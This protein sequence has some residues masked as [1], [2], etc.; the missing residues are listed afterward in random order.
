[1]RITPLLGTFVFLVACEGAVGLKSRNGQTPPPTIL[2]YSADAGTD[3][4]P[5]PP[6]PPP[7]CTPSCQGR[8]CGDDGCGGVCGSCD[9]T[10]TC[11]GGSCVPNAPPPSTQGVPK[12]FGRVATCGSCRAAHAYFD[13]HHITYEAHDFSEGYDGYMAAVMAA[14]ET[15][16]SSISMPA[17]VWGPH[18]VTYGWSNSM[19]T[20]RG[21]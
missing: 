8:S 16:R 11:T 10:S 6:P 5:P 21:F 2:T 7:G 14:G 12:V 9:A 18:D 19:A 17:I 1:M 15:P 3:A 13:S 20:S 4:A